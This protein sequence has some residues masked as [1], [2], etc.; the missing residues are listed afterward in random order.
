MPLHGVIAVLMLV[1]TEEV[2][3]GAFEIYR[4]SVNRVAAGVRSLL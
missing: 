3:E 4:G 2:E 1:R